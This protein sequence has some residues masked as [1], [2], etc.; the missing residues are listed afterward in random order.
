MIEQSQVF[1][2]LLTFAAIFAFTVKKRLCCLIVFGAGC[3]LTAAYGAGLVAEQFLANQIQVVWNTF[4][5]FGSG[6]VLVSLAS[7]S[8]A[9]WLGGQYLEVNP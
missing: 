3:A 1:W 8:F 5:K 2:A 7:G 6:N 9:R 4:A